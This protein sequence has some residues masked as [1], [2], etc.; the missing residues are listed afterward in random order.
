MTSAIA[1]ELVGPRRD[2]S[3]L[4]AALIEMFELGEQQLVHGGCRRY[5]SAGPD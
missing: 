5:H 3:S 4:A 1:T 2:E